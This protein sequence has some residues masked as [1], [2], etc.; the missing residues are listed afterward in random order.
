MVY[1]IGIRGDYVTVEVSKNGSVREAKAAMCRACGIPVSLSQ[2][3]RQSVGR[4]MEPMHM[5]ESHAYSSS[6]Q[7][8]E[9][10]EHRLRM[11]NFLKE[12]ACDPPVAEE[13]AGE[14][15]LVRKSDLMK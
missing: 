11:T 6:W 10:Q 4:S 9:I 14:E 8:H 15:V 13:E 12:E 1:L 7:E 5:S 2:R 3:V